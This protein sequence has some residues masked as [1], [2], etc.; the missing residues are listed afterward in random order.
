[1]PLPFQIWATTSVNLWKKNAAFLL[2]CD[3]ALCLLCMSDVDA[4]ATRVAR[5]MSVKDRVKAAEEQRK[6][7]G[8]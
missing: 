6:S 1:M 4:V 8:E 3:C 2:Y 7:K 5:G